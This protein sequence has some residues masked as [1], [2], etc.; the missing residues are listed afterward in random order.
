[1]NMKLKCNT[2]KNSTLIVL[3]VIILINSDNLFA[4]KLKFGVFADPVISWFSSDTHDT[5]SKG[6]R[7]GFNFGVTFNKYFT[8]NYAFSTGINILNA[9]GQISNS[10]PVEMQFKNMVASVP[11]GESVIYKI[12]YLSVPLG[13]KFNTNQIG[14]ISF[15]T[16]LG[17]DPKVVIGGKADIPSLEISGENAMDELRQF[18]LSYHITAGAEYSIGGTTSLVFGLGFDN[19]FLDAT[20][21]NGSQPIDKISHKIIKFQFGINF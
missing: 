4:Q 8:D 19:N 2:F 18:N 16:D 3:I 7:A 5:Q 6:A 9:G 10:I 12:Q 17:I 13:L 14:Y 11:A 15:F 21:D 1:M 20:K